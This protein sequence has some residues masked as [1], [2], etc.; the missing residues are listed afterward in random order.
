MVRDEFWGRMKNIQRVHQL[1]YAV[2]LG[3]IIGKII[4]LLITTGRKTGLKRIT[5]LQYEVIDGKYYVG[6]ARGTKSDWCRNIQA[7]GRVEVRVKNLFF[8]GLAETVTDPARTADFLE[9]RLERHP[10]MMGLLMKKVY[11]LPKRPIRQQL[12]DLAASEA[13]IIIQPVEEY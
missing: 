12:L 10:F 2:G 9:T 6:S 8:R 13:I 5:P 7:D 3:P 4:L 1:L 11:S